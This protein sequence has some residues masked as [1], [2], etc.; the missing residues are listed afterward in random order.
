M[1]GPMCNLYNPFTG[2]MMSDVTCSFISLKG[3]NLQ[4]CDGAEGMVRFVV[5]PAQI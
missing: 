5:D 4:W 2:R 3:T 1:R